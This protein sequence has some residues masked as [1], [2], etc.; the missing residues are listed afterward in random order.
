[1]KEMMALVKSEKNSQKTKPS[2]TTMICQ[3]G[4]ERK[5]L[6]KDAK[7]KTAH[8]FVNIATESTLQRKQRNVGNSKQMQHPVHCTGNHPREPEDAWG[9][10]KKQRCGNQAKCC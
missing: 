3:K 9:L 10:K 7:C 1:M 4:E 2:Q 6:K 5:E 8:Q